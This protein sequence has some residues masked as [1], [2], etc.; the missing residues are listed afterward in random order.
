MCRSQWLS[1][2]LVILADNF[3]LWITNLIV[4]LV[5]GKG[6]LVTSLAER[7]TMKGFCFFRQRPLEPLTQFLPFCRFYLTNP[8][9]RGQWMQPKIPAPRDGLVVPAAVSRLP[10]GA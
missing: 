6:V 4:E 2:K 9:V 10:A 7:K 1:E 8:Q 5:C 3:E